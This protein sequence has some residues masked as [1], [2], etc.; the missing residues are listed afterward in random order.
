MPSFSTH[1]GSKLWGM[2]SEA[3]QFVKV[4]FIETLFSPYYLDLV[5]CFLHIWDLLDGWKQYIERIP[6]A[7]EPARFAADVV[8]NVYLS[9]LL[10]A[11]RNMRHRFG[12]FSAA[13]ST[14][15]QVNLKI[16]FWNI[17]GLS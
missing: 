13:L 15:V 8:W 3:L 5:I 11:L 10:L 7:L 16:Q 12:L 4:R 6:F 17:S 1:H 9:S 2:F 14:T